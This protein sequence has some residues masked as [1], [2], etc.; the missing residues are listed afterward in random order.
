M[1]GGSHSEPPG[2]GPQIPSDENPL[3]AIEE[4]EE[5]LVLELRSYL[6]VTGSKEPDGHRQGW[7]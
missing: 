6:Q 4:V 5:E 3:G 7:D 1:K 2:N